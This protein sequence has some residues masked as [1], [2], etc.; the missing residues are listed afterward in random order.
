MKQA[1]INSKEF[2]ELNPILLRVQ[3]IL[4]ELLLFSL[5]NSITCS[6]ELFQAAPKIMRLILQFTQ[7]IQDKAK[8]KDSFQMNGEEKEMLLSHF[9]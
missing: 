3:E 4:K 9:L 6:Q 5:E 1:Y 8:T 7:I 2:Q